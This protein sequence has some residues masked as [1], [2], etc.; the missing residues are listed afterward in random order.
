MPADGR[1]LF[2]VLVSDGR[3]GQ[4]RGTLVLQAGGAVGVNVAPRVDSV[5]QSLTQANGGQGVTLGLTAHDPEGKTVSF[6][7]SAAAGAILATRWTSSSGEADWVAPACFDAAVSITASVTDA[8]GA[9]T[10]RVFS[11]SPSESAKCGALSVSGLRRVHHVQ[12]DGSILVT[13]RLPAP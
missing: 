12:Q 13:P 7:W 11:V 5:F 4:H 3:G 6:S 8:D 2:Q 10:Q 1:C 9:R